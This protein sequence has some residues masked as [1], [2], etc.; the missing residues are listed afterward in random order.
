MTNVGSN[1]LI[2]NFIDPVCVIRR[3]GKAYTIELPRKMRA[4][5]SFYFGWLRA[6]HQFGGFNGE[7]SPCAR[8]SPIGSCA[9]GAENHP[10]PEARISSCGDKRYHDELHLARREEIAVPARSQAGRKQIENDL[11]RV[12][13]RSDS[14]VLASSEACLISTRGHDATYALRTRA[15]T[16]SQTD[17]VNPSVDVY[18]PPPQPLVDACGGQRFPV[19][20][21][22]NP[23]DVKGR[24]TSYLVR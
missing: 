24:R 17:S 22:L 1:K 19:E 20:R 18:P 16:Q 13:R 8:T 15:D 2:T 6:Y 14:S 12:P 4:H 10:T 7:E 11:S 9:R 23:C 21:L 5:P 3:R